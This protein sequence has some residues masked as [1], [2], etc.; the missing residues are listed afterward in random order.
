[1]LDELL[2]I[3]TTDEFEHDG[4]MHLSA[5]SWHGDSLRLTLVVNDGDEHITTWA[6]TCDGVFEYLLSRAF[7]AGLNVWSDH[8]VI[9]QYVQ[10]WD[11]LY[12]AASSSEPD[13]VVGKLWAAHCT[14]VGDW[15]PFDRY[16]N[17]GMPLAQLLASGSG[18]VADGPRFLM[19]AYEAVLNRAGCR[20]NRRQ[21][22]LPQAAKAQMA[23]FGESY[24]VAATISV[25]RS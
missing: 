14:E 20:P 19:A 23:H 17:T 12:F 2:A 10:P 25:V 24:V 9:S 16:L 18:M 13:A 1:M 6:M 15:L 11:E 22:R 4:R 7:E 8:P 21:S 5:A 3:T